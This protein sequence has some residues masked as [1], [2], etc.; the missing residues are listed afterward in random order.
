[1]IVNGGSGIGESSSNFVSVH[2]PWEKRK[3]KSSFSYKLNNKAYW[4]L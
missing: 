2:F 1:M 4:I 3:S